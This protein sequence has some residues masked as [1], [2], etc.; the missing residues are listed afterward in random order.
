MGLQLAVITI[1]LMLAVFCVALDNTIMAVAIPKITDQF[2][3]LDD[4]G[5]YGSSYLLTTCSFQLLYGKLYTLFSIKWVFLSALFVFKLG[6]LICGVAPD[7]VTLIVGRAIAGLGSAG[8]FTGAMVTL[9]HTVAPAKRPMF[10]SMLGGMYG[11][12]SVAGPLMGGVFTDHATWRWCFYI[13]LPLGGV[14]AIGLLTLLRLPAKP[15][16]QRK[17]LVATLKGLDPLGTVIF[18]PAI[19][20]LLL[21]LQWGGVTYL[22]SSGRVIALFVIFALALLAFVGLQLFLGE[23]ATVPIGIA[24]QRTIASA[25]L[26]GLCIGGSFFTLIYYIP[27]W[28]VPSDPQRHRRPLRNQ[29][30]PMI[31]SNVVGI[32]VSGALTT[33]FGYNAPFFLLSSG[34]MSLGAGLII[35]FTVDISQA[36]WVGFLFLYGLG[37]GFGFQQGGVAA[38]AVLPLSQVSVGTA[39]VMF[40]QMLGGSLFVSVAENIFSKHLIANIAALDIPGLSPEAVVAAGATGFRALVGAEDLPA[41]LVAYNDA[42]VKVFQLALILGCL[43]LSGAVG[44][45]W[46]SIRGKEIDMAAA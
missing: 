7:S 22:W 5:W 36:K 35:T 31:L 26:F 11:I 18:V 6:S 2:H 34:I 43:S 24:R 3:A 21:A 15:Q 41:V 23:D 17:S 46:R 12:A 33:A 4:V 44:V 14:K 28:V 1:S 40:T 38:Q 32:I 25:S 37:V 39:I 10:F 45:E 13:N 29:L 9:A 42:L 16:T 27:I 20:C 8:I 19:V 30:P